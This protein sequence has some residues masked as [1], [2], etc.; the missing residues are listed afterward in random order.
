VVVQQNVMSPM[1]PVNCGALRENDAPARW[2]AARTCV[3]TQSE[4]GSAFYVTWPQQA[5]R[6]AILGRPGATY[7]LTQ[8]LWYRGCGGNAIAFI[9]ACGALTPTPGCDA[10]AP[11]LCLECAAPAPETMACGA[12][13]TC[14]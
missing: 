14:Q 6:R 11:L 3:R 7:E 8:V 4:A 9:G 2:E 13:Q 1:P 12:P 5:A 10:M